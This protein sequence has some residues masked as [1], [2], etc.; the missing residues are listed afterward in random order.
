MMESPAERPYTHGK[1]SCAA[2]GKQ[3]IV[4]STQAV[5]MANRSWTLL[6]LHR[7]LRADTCRES[8]ILDAAELGLPNCRVE[9]TTLHGGL[10]DGVRLVTL[11]NGRVR[12]AVIPDRGMGIWKSWLGDCEIGWNSPVRG[13]VHPKFVPLAEP[14]GLGWLDGFDE[15]LCRCGL[16]SNG[17]PE[18]DSRGTLV[19]PLHGRI[20]NRPAHRLVVE[21]DAGAGELRVTGVVDECRFHFHKLRLTST[22]RMRVG[23]PRLE[24]SD[25]VTNLAGNPGEMQLLYHINFGPPICAPGS[26]MLAPVKRLMPRDPHSAKTVG[27]WDQY[28]PP[29]AQSVEQVF[30]AELS[31]DSGGWT[32]ALLASPAGDRGASVQFR[33]AELPCF[34]LWK[35]NPPLADGYVTGL[36]PGTNFP[37]PRSFE[38]S[39]GRVRK[40]TPGEAA[41]LELALEFHN[42]LSAV[43]Q[44]VERIA[45]LQAQAAADICESPQPG[46]TVGQ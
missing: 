37:N 23:R 28:G 10:R 7:D 45:R 43:K 2:D 42:T 3:H 16:L 22:L 34:S 40:L 38:A 4:R 1:R 8:A 15:L 35:N 31:P 26:R 27:Q 21:A 20:A 11:D 24:I 32:E 44:A 5:I 36:E 19:Y 14:S 30:F 9:L 39:Q 41:R 29:E 33:T 18:F 46:W 13:P 6:D 17:A 25:E 12:V